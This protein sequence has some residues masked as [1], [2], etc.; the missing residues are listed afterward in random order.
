MTPTRTATPLTA[1][2]DTTTSHGTLRLP[3]MAASRMS[4]IPDFFGTDTFTYHANDGSA[5]S[6][7][8]TVT[9]TVNAVNDAPIG[10]PDGYSTNED[11]TLNVN[12]TADGLVNN[13]SDP[14]G[15][16]L[17]AVSLVQ[18]AHG[19]VNQFDPDGTFRYVPNA[20]F[21]GTD[22][23]TYR[24][25]DGT[26]QSAPVTVTVTV[27]PVNDTPVATADS[28]GTNEDTALVVSA[29]GVLGNDTDVDG[30]TLTAAA[31]VQPG[32]GALSL[33]LERRASRTRPPR[34]TAA[35]TASPIGPTTGRSTRTR[36][37][38][39]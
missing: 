16:T 27:D 36:S 25:S 35:P 12:Q 38:C 1:V 3:P 39:R 11:T 19:T 34:T 7:T 17:T 37:P 33:S 10:V 6:G 8:A 13:D 29:P 20:N 5:D 31:V 21:N 14:E 32:H 9:I 30:Q 18:P 15:S 26:A 2:V 23:F 24:A 22:T 28:Y 4:R